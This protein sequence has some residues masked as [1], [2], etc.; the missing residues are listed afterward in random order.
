MCRF[1]PLNSAKFHPVNNLG[2]PVGFPEGQGEADTGTD[3][4]RGILEGPVLRRGLGRE[5]QERAL[6]RPH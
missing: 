3:S 6:V 4:V 5:E 2:V 1:H